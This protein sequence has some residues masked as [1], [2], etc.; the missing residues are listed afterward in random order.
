MISIPDGVY[1][2]VACRLPHRLRR[3][4]YQRCRGGL[5]KTPRVTTV[6]PQDDGER[7]PPVDRRREAQ[8]QGADRAEASHGSGTI[9][10]VILQ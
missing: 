1:E 5:S 2:S 9:S 4:R 6:A 3:R 10:S 8:V 7:H